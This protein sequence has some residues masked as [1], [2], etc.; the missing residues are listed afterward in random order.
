MVGFHMLHQGARQNVF[1]VTRREGHRHAVDVRGALDLRRSAAGGARD[2]GAG[3]QG[4]GGEMA[5]RDRRSA[6]LPGARG[7]RGEHDRG[8]LSVCPARAGRRRDAVRHRRRR[9]PARQRRGA[10]EAAAAGGRPREA[11]RRCSATSRKASGSIRTR[12]CSWLPPSRR[13]ASAGSRLDACQ[14]QRSGG[15]PLSPCRRGCGEA[16]SSSKHYL[17]RPLT[18]PLRGRPLHEGE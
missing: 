4:A 18:R 17:M 9:A 2:E 8:G 11:R 7:R 5:G 16:V 1:P 10:A 14:L 15:A 3:R 12:R 13:S 6:R